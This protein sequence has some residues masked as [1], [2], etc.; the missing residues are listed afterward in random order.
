MIL[1]F[2]ASS[3]VDDFNSDNVTLDTG[4]TGRTLKEDSP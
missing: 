4:T 1:F 3:L 2:K